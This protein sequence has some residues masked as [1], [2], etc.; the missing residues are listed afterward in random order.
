MFFI[1][2]LVLFLVQILWIIS[3]AYADSS[4]MQMILTS[5]GSLLI[6]QAKLMGPVNPDKKINFTVWLKLRNKEQLDQMVSEIYDQKSVNYHKFLTY[7]EFN[8]HYAPS[9]DVE[10]KVQLYFTALGMRAKIVNHSVRVTATVQQI[11]RH[12]LVHMNH[13]RYQNRTVY[14][15]AT[16]PVVTSAIGQYVL[17]ISGLSNL[18]RF[19]PALHARP[20]INRKNNIS[21][22]LHLVWDSFIPSAQPTTTSL[23]GF[24]GAQ[25]QTTYTLANIT[26]IQGKAIDGAGQTLVIIDACGSNSSAQIMADANL[27]NNANEITPFILNENFAVINPDGSTYTTCGTPGTTG[28]E[29]E[30]ALDV[31]SSH[32]LIP[33]ANTVLVLSRNDDAPLDTAVHDVINTLISNNYTIAGFSNAYVVSNS[34]G[35]SETMGSSP[36]METDFET[37]AAHGLSFNFSTGD[38]GDGTYNSS[39]PCTSYGVQPS[40]EYPASSAYTTAVGGSSVFVDNN[41]NYAFEMVWGSYYQGAFYGGTTGGISQYYGPVSWQNSISG[42]TAGGYNSGTV[43]YYNKRALPD[44]AMLA[45]PYTGLTIYEGGQSFVYGG[46]S[47]AC[48]LFSAT[49]TLI[50]QARTVLN[51]NSPNPI[52]QV[53]PYL[54]TNNSTLLKTK[55]LHL[56]TPPHQ[57]IDG[58]R[59]PPAGAPLSAFK[60][61]DSFYNYDLTFGWDSSLTIAPENQFWNDGVGVG[62]PNL[63]DF[64]A[65]MATL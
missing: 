6:N 65:I 42:F 36:S 64:V 24:T 1:K 9:Q 38:C 52:G 57:I 63:P 40:V 46:T 33:G 23:A 18:S 32:T 62:S 26:P 8:Q 37:A 17:E 5:P 41:W 49:A 22:D 29:D 2:R 28:W 14:A 44:I 13:Y 50:N 7:D 59:P 58:A 21:Q 48:P 3:T 20:K 34:W 11:E 27:Y 35:I 47:L 39:W 61:H 10:N 4:T 16:P 56:I 30:I 53:A 51:G 45:D 55:A 25:L 54:Y 12:L 31:E 60:I 19:Q 15:N 43:G